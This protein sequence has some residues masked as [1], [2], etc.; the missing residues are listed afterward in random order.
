MIAW[1]DLLAAIALVLILEGILPFASPESMRKVL[2]QMQNIGDRQ[3]RRMG[4][5]SVIAGLVLLY[6][7]KN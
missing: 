6:F 2:E 5:A 7:V 4:A 1:Q 3:L